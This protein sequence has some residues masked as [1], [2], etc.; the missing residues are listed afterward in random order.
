MRPKI[1]MTMKSLIVPRAYPRFRVPD[2]V[3]T[4]R[5]KRRVARLLKQIQ[6][7]DDESGVPV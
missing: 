6:V 1:L 5:N 4:E 2:A 3:L 7:A